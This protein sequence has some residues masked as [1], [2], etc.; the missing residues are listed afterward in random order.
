MIQSYC[1]LISLGAAFVNNEMIYEEYREEFRKMVFLAKEVLE[2][3]EAARVGGARVFSFSIGV[4][5]SLYFVV[6]I[7]RDRA[8]RREVLE[9]CGKYPRQDGAWDS[10]MVAAIGK[11]NIEI[12]EK[13]LKG[14]EPIPESSRVRLMEVKIPSGK[15]ELLIR[16]TVMEGTK[17][18]GKSNATTG[19]NCVVTVHFLTLMG[20]VER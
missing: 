14:D 16:Y 7:C 19:E 10:A 5:T 15:K 8:V 2:R 17:C 20:L 6:N 11:W 3:A 13:G 4:I 18:E 12:Q 9:L 1:A